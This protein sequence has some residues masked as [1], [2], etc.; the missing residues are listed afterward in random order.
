MQVYADSTDW[1]VSMDDA[2]G[3][4]IIFALSLLFVILPLFT[5]FLQLHSAIQLWVTDIETRRI[6]KAWIQVYLHSLY[7]F[8]ILFGSAF[9]AVEI[10]NSNLFS[11][12]V[13][14][15]AWD[16][17]DVKWHYLKINVFIH[18]F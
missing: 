14:A 16:L 12:P 6:V 4:V 17:I 5:N 13:F 3:Y 7:L 1:S 9:T 8:S 10:C 18:Q 15:M 2:V 11:L